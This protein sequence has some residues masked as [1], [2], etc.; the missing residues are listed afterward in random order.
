MSTDDLTQIFERE[1]ANPPSAIEAQAAVAAL[2]D[3]YPAGLDTYSW[4]SRTELRQ[5]AEQAAATDAGLLVDLGCG[6]GGPGLW[7]AGTTDTRLIGVDIAESA[8]ERARRLAGQLGVD[9]EFRVG[10]FEATGLPDSTADLV[11]SFDAFL[12]TPDKQ[13]AFVELTR[14]LRPGGRVAMTSWDYHSQ[15]RN[16]PPQIADH[17]PLAE[18]AGFSVLSYEET[19][20]WRRRC[21]VF[22]E[23]LLERVEELAAEAA[24][25]VQE[26]LS[27]L[28]DMRASI[29]CMT[30]RFLLVAER[31]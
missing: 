5:V 22:A 30:R 25:P 23:F 10:S 7:V 9:A 4:V 17:R 29:D 14:V 26:M 3:E 21:V 19:D 24:V 20:D 27:G 2:G 12:F 11:M 16:R 1:F 13:A 6:R 8:L 31:R 15:P 28:D 18:Y